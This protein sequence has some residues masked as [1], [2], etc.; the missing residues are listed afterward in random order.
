MHN[1]HTCSIGTLLQFMDHKRI[2]KHN[3]EHIDPD[4]DV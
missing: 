2:Y 3:R 1:T 4:I